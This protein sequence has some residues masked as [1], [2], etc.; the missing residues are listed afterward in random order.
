MYILAIIFKSSQNVLQLFLNISN[1]Q[2]ANSEPLN[3]DVEK[4]EV[5]WS[6]LMVS[7]MENEVPF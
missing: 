3:L 7:K 6:I 2:V 1:L 5:L 4:S